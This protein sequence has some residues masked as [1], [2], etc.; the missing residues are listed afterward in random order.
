MP[1]HILRPHAKPYFLNTEITA[2]KWPD[3]TQE[4]RVARAKFGRFVREGEGI[5]DPA[6][7]PTELAF[8]VGTSDLK[9]FLSVEFLWLV[10]QPVKDLIEELDPTLH[11]FIS[12]RVTDHTG[13]PFD[14]GLWWMLIVHHRQASIV[15]E[16]TNS[17]P[18]Q[19][20]K[21]TRARMIL[22]QSGKITMD[23]SNLAANVHLWR[24]ERYGSALFMSDLLY[25]R[26]EDMGVE[27]PC[28]PVELI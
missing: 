8:M 21:R 17:Y 6:D 20:A 2:W 7:A 26:L 28:R 12:L 22:K 24:E 10:K 23:G 5:A 25:G 19:E 9:Q 16:L 13:T 14:K 18:G 1:K 27:L 4:G 15:D 11:Q 3:D